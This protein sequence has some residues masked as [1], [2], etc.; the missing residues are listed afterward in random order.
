MILL[1]LNDQIIKSLSGPELAILKYAYENTE[2]LLEMSI[3]KFADHAACS[4]A[5]VL[6]FCKKLGYSGYAE[7]K[8][9]LRAEQRDENILVNAIEAC[10]KTSSN[11]V[12][13]ISVQIINKKLCIIEKNT[14]SGNLVLDKAGIPVTT[15]NDKKNHGLG[16]KN[17]R[18]V[19]AKHDGMIKFTCED[20]WF[21]IALHI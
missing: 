18:D 20:G 5:T 14:M 2:T 3:R 13:S 12:V 15:K 1:R 16:T 19:V 6:R 10:E 4:P 9:A 11:R 8:Y 7:F 17:I 21:E